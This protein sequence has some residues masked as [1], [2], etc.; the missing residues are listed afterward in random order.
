[1]TAAGGHPV[2]P[3]GYGEHNS[4]LH[5]KLQLRGSAPWVRGTPT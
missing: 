4:I 2:Q 3:R 5:I 1:M